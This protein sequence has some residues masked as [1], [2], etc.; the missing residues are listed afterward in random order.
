MATVNNIFILKLKSLVRRFMPSLMPMSLRFSSRFITM[1]RERDYFIKGVRSSNSKEMSLALLSQPRAGTQVCEA[2][3]EELYQSTGGLSLNTGKFFFHYNASA[4]KKVNNN[5]WIENNLEKSGYFYGH[6]GPFSSL[7]GLPEIQYIL[8]TRDPRDVLVSHY[9]SVREAHVINSKKMM[10]KVT[11]LKEMTLSEYCHYEPILQDLERYIAQTE[12]IRTSILSHLY[13]RYE[14]LMYD[15]LESLEK[16]TKFLDVKGIDLSKMSQEHFSILKDGEDLSSHRRSGKWGQFREKLSRNDQEYLWER[17]GDSIKP[18]G[19][20][21]D[22][23]EKVE[24][25]FTQ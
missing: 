6:L 1:K 2:V 16:I 4:A 20:H 21:K 19:Y 15:P 7:E 3:I 8:M 17:F 25:P 9:Y 11:R 5:D 14:D 10:E 24:Q 22:N 23:L 13:I 12:L 18:L